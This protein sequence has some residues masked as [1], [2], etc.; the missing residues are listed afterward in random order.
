M[1][2]QEI[3][4]NLIT[5]QDQLLCIAG[6]TSGGKLQFQVPGTAYWMNYPL[7]VSTLNTGMSDATNVAVFSFT[8]FTCA[9]RYVFTTVPTANYWYSITP[10]TMPEF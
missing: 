3:Y 2:A 5:G 8:A 6:A 9:H 1:S 4:F 10:V 7:M